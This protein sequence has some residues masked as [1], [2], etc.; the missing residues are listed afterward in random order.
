MLFVPALALSC[1]T[2]DLC[3]RYCCTRLFPLTPFVVSLF[4]G[5]DLIDRYDYLGYGSECED[6]DLET[7]TRRS[8]EFSF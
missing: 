4:T 7:S 1:M 3:V 8:L 6:Y 2:C 5:D